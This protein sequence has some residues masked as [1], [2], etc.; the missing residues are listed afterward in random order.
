MLKLHGIKTR[1]HVYRSLRS[2][3]LQALCN[4]SYT[5]L[6]LAQCCINNMTITHHSIQKQRTIVKE[7]SMGSFMSWYRC[8]SLFSHIISPSGQ[9]LLM[10]IAANNVR[11][12]QVGSLLANCSVAQEACVTP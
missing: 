5:A 7:P 2:V 10:C 4:N 11:G 8:T 9:M 1:F 6:K 3:H 12:L